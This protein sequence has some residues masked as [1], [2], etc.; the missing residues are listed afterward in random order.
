MVPFSIIHKRWVEY[1]KQGFFGYKRIETQ[2]KKLVECKF[3]SNYYSINF[4]TRISSTRPITN[5]IYQYMT[6][7]SKIEKKIFITQFDQDFENNTSAL[8]RQF[9]DVFLAKSNYQNIFALFYRFCANVYRDSGCWMGML[10]HILRNIVCSTR[11]GQFVGKTRRQQ[12]PSTLGS[13]T[14][15]CMYESVCMK[16]GA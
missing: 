15:I 16:N 8:S 9:T 13:Y 14:Q 3:C 2:P 7:C 6:N 12:F 1:P 11:G 10:L 4:N 5:H